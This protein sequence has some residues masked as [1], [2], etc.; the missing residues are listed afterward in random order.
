VC[1]P[2]TLVLALALLLGTAARA[3][4]SPAREQRQRSIT[5]TGSPADPPPEIHVAKG[6]ATLL[7]FKS[8]LNRDAVD[9]DGRSSRITVDVGDGS[10][11]L[12]PLSDLGVAERLVVSAP[13]ADGQRAVF[14]LV[15][16]PSEVD[17]RVDVIRRE[18]PDIACQA[19]AAPCAAVSPAD[20]VTS[21]L[22]DKQGVQTGVVPSFN[23][24]ASGFQS[25]EGVSYRAGNWVLV[26]MEIIPPP[27]HP[28][29]RPTGATLK[30]KTGAVRV[31]AVKV[32]PGMVFPGEGVRVF[33]ETDVPSPSAGHEFVL[34]LDGGDD[35]PSFSIPSVTLPPALEGK[36]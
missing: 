32:E 15:S 16:S 11:I 29:W 14:V 6:V 20:A 22:L 31:R 9:V 7:R 13:F 28:A 2:I 5:V 33:V 10:I 23:D 25:R 35:A 27:R 8:Q 4:P 3:Q 34:R 12:E 17:T 24:A 21:G 18:P 1:Q 19:P 36:R 26:D 30:G